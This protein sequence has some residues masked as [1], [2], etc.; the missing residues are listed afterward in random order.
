MSNKLDTSPYKGVRDFYPEDMWLEK[1]M[2]ETMRKAVESYGYVEYTASILEPAELYKAKSGQEIVNEQTYTFT[3]RGNREVTLRPEMTPTVAR[4]VAGRRRDLGFPLRW[5]SIP[6]LFR[7]ENP[8]RGR[9][10]EH[11]Q[12][13]VDVFGITG[14]SAEVEI[15][16]VANAI[17]QG[18]G[19]HDA[20]YSI[21]I[22]SRKLL[23]ELF[24]LFN[25]S[26]EKSY[27]LSK[28]IDKKEKVS[29][30]DFLSGVEELI[31]DN[32]KELVA[33]LSSNQKLLERIGEDH[34]TVKTILSVITSLDQL[35]IKNVIFTPT[36]M[37]GFDYYTDIVFEVFD[38]HPENNRSLFGGGRYDNLLELFG[39][40]SVPAVGFGMGDV[41]LAD[42]LR[43]HNLLPAYRSEVGAVLATIG[44]VDEN[45]VAIL[46][47][48]FR[49]KG[50][51]VAVTIGA[52]KPAD[53]I[54]NTL[55]QGV[56]YIIFVGEDELS[57]KVYTFKD[58]TTEETSSLSFDD[59][60]RSIQS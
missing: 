13:N 26:E 45:E 15:I 9:L 16:S 43:T 40:D 59:I 8:Q 17:M 25:I 46:A 35:G 22:N 21:L 28:L 5:Y 20:D 12:L 56:K 36:L 30:E 32:A 29:A 7:Y 2:F 19:A 60:V 57:K 27:T 47:Q 42:F 37:R 31:G 6:N 24:E 33:L 49:S 1:Y 23:K 50:L 48:S 54:K 51:N 10:R 58:L 55:K 4:M 39:N 38:T 14:L 11:Y 53:V 52:K 44:A 3:D 34:E 18:F 41:T